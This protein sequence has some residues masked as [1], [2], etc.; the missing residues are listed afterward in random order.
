MTV[1]DLVKFR[2]SEMHEFY[3]VGVVAGPP[4]NHGSKVVPYFD[5]P[6]YFKDEI[7]RAR[8]EELEVV[9]ESR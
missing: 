9:N 3:G 8:E 7:I 5:I 2:H 1:G 4:H 6:V